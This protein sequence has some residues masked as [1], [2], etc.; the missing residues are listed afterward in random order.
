MSLS[1]VSIT[2]SSKSQMNDNISIYCIGHIEGDHFDE[3][4]H[5]ELNKETLDDSFDSAPFNSSLYVIVVLLIYIICVTRAYKFSKSLSY[6]F[7][8]LR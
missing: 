4:C 3:K 8:N 7:V 6:S 1:V 5:Y 2:Y